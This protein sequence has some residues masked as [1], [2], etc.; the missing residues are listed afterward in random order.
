[1]ADKKADPGTC[2]GCGESWKGGR[3]LEVYEDEGEPV[4]SYC[5][6]CTLKAIQGGLRYWQATEKARS[7]GI[8][9][10]IGGLLPLNA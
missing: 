8:D 7:A 10:E 1:M 6:S 9:P 4:Y 3:R 2:N 5:P